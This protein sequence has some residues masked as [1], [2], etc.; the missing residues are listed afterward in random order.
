MSAGAVEQVKRAVG[1]PAL[2]RAPALFRAAAEAQAGRAVLWWPVGLAAG[3]G[4]FVKK[5]EAGA[6]KVM[7][8]GSSVPG[9][10]KGL[11]CSNRFL[12]G[13]GSTH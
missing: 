13:P 9:E 4:F 11:N 6:V 3:T 5:D 12:T 7:V 2:P 8:S 10:R 1:L